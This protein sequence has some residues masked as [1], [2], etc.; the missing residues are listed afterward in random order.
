MAYETSKFGDGSAAGSG[1]VTQTVHNHYGQRKVG[2]TVGDLETDGS[3]RELVI[4][5]D[6]SMVSAAGFPLI[7][8]TL[9]AGSRVINVFAEVQEAFVLGGTTPAI[10]V[11]TEGSEVT[12]GFTIS[13]TIAE[14]LGTYSLTSALSGTWAG[15]TGLV[16]D[17][18]LGIALT[19]GTPTITAAGKMRIVIQYFKI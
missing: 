1:N 12:N 3:L 16:A 4:D 6:A 5:L 18:I 19:G 15:A 17:T 7:A 11:G 9:L 10:E 8:P 14:A 2:K 13:E